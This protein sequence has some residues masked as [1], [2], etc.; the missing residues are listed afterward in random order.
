MKKKK[1]DTITQEKKHIDNTQKTLKKRFSVT[2]R[3]VWI[4]NKYLYGI[5]PE[6][7]S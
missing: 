5:C 2:D 3:N 1:T 4:T 6:N 7:M